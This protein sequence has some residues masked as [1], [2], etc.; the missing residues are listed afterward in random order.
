MVQQLQNYSGFSRS[1]RTNSVVT[2]ISSRTPQTLGSRLELRQTARASN[3]TLA[4]AQVLGQLPGPKKT[5]N[6]A[7][8]QGNSKDF[9]RLNVTEPSRLRLAFSNRSTAALTAAI[10]D[11]SGKVVNTQG[12]QQLVRVGAGEQAETLFRGANPGTY[13]LRISSPNSGNN[14][15]RVNLFANSNQ[16]PQPLPCGCGL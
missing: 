7:V 14:R 10:L 15:Y 12:R 9:F 16:I 8:G 5:V 3:G 2:A 1:G 13:Y 4:T 11:A 6:D